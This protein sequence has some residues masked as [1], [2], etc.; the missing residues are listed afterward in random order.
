MN[1][2]FPKCPNCDTSFPV[3]TRVDSG[4]KM[5]VPTDLIV[6][7]VCYQCNARVDLTL[8]LGDLAELRKMV[9]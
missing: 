2:L 4:T 1:V 5:P 9:S 6:E 7:C 8:K 3:F